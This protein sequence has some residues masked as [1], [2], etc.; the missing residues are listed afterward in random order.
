MTSIFQRAVDHYGVDSQLS[1]AL[2]E[3]IELTHEL[4]KLRNGK[5]DLVA[6]IGELADAE[7]MLAQMRVIYGDHEI[8]KAID[9]KLTRLEQRIRVAD[10]IRVAP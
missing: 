8:D 4:I 10:S 9:A 5:G 1:K 2:E 3:F 7:I 6:L